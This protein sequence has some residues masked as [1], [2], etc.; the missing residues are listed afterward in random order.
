MV[1]KLDN[2]WF[3]F[4]EQK[5]SV[6]IFYPDVLLVGDFLPK[7]TGKLFKTSQRFDVR[8]G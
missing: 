5:L 7:R 8:H 2:D 4:F 6:P 1:L 3:V